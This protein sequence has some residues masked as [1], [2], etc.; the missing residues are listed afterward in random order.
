MYK[1]IPKEI[2]D[3]VSY[4]P[5]TG[6]IT[7]LSTG[8]IITTQNS[9][10]YIVF[11]GKDRKLYQAG[12]VAWFLHTGED[13][14][15][16]V[17]DHINQQI[18]D[19]RFENLRLLDRRKNRVN[20]RSLGFSKSKDPRNAKKPYR[21]SFKRKGKRLHNS[22]HACPLLARLAYLDCVF[23]HTGITVATDACFTPY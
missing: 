18:N 14:G 1:P 19:N 17:V 9:A 15:N 23:E 10:G 22:M 5:E 16:F 20:S 2:K 3:W 6:E 4:N 21:V 11:T 7:R 12:R 8:N 13:P